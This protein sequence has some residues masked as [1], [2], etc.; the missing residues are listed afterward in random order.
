[1]VLDLAKKYACLSQIFVEG[2]N[3]KLEKLYYEVFVYVKKPYWRV[4]KSK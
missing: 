3:K 4:I 2:L 1:M